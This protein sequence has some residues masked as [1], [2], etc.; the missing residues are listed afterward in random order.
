MR[1]L[2]LSQAKSRLSEL[3]ADVVATEEEITITRN[4]RAAVVLVRYD[5]FQR[6]KETDEIT[7]NPDFLREVRQ[8][9]SD[10]RRGR[11]RLLRDADL[12][13]LLGETRRPP[14][15]SRSK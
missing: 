10:L 9:I 11:G 7:A 13:R 6:W 5:D 3:V 1:V 2:P 8:G 4:G 14:R 12:D 15:R